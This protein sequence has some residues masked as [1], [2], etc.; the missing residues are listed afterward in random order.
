MSIARKAA[1]LKITPCPVQV[2]NFTSRVGAT[3]SSVKRVALGSE[4]TRSPTVP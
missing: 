4:S 3:S 2:D 1:V